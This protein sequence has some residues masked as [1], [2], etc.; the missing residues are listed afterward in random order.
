MRSVGRLR[1]NT[2]GAALGGHVWDRAGQIW[3]DTPTGGSLA[4]DPD[5][6]AFATATAGTAACLH[7]AMSAEANVV[8]K[9]WKRVGVSA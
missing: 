5:F 1:R 3:Y 7:G 9:A 2:V 6:A 4:A 8:Q